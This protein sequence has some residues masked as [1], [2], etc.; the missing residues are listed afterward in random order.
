M[1]IAVQPTSLGQ[2]EINKADIV[3]KKNRKSTLL[4]I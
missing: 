2:T 3:H 4:E 1:P